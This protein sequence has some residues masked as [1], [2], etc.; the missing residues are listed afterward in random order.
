GGVCLLSVQ[1]GLGG[2][3][4]AVPSRHGQKGGVWRG[5]GCDDD[6]CRLLHRADEGGG[7]GLRDPEPL[8]EGRQGTGGGI[9]EGAQGREQHGQ[10]DVD[11]LIRFALAHAEQA[12]LDHLKAVCLQVGE[13]EEQPV[14]G[15]RQRAVFV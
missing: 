6:G 3:R 15:G 11:P 1:Q 7:V 5:N 10:E 14:F 4:C 9:A 8:G 12:S 2:G 13:Q